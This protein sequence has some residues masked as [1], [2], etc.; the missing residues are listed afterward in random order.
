MQHLT[1]LIA[2]YCLIAGLKR[3][4]LGHVRLSVL[5]EAGSKYSRLLYLL[6]LFRPREIPLFNSYDHYILLI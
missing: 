6:G 5:H 2:N 3:N 1:A 4:L